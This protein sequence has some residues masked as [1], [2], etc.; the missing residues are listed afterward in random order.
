MRLRNQS[1]HLLIK[2]IAVTVAGSVALA[3]S[4]SIPAWAGDPFRRDNPQPIGAGTEAA[5]K[6]IFEQGNYQAAAELLEAAEEDEPLTHAMRTS[7]YYLEG[8]LEA[9]GESATT[10]LRTAEALIATNPLRGNLY[11]A[12]GHFLEGAHVISTQGVVRATPTVL[13]K[14]QQVFDHLDEA[15]RIDPTDPE[16]N[17]LRGYMD[18]ML[19]VNLPFS[20]P[21]QA[22]ARLQNYAAPSYLALRG[23][24]IGYRDLD[25]E[26]AALEAVNQALAETPQNPDLFYLKAQI[27]RLQDKT[28]ESLTFFEQAL[29]LEA[30]LPQALANQIAY[31]HCRV[32]RDIQQN[33]R[34]NCSALLNRE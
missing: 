31:E 30:Q 18:L 33:N 27:L 8:D 16:L 14:L 7:F 24:A 3:L 32:Q 28:Q 10:T 20:D 34:Q 6:A 15:E 19:A 12:V 22:I 2:Q 21:N 9:M 26:E 23:I 13:A 11:I 5:F 17:L 1:R 25:Q 4:V 29:S